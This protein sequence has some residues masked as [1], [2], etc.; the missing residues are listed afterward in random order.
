MGTWENDEDKAQAMKRQ[1]EAFNRIASVFETIASD[2]RSFTMACDSF[3]K[4]LAIIADAYDYQH[5]RPKV[6]I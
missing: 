5:G 6:K 4:S 1:A 2:F 3:A